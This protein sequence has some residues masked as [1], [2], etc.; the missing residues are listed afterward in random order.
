MKGTIG[1]TSTI[2]GI[3]CLFIAI[4]QLVQTGAPAAWDS[5]VRGDIANVRTV[6]SAEFLSGH[7]Y[8]T[9]LGAPTPSGFS[10]KLSAGSESQIIATSATYVMVS[11]SNSG[12]IFISTADATTTLATPTAPVTAA[13]LGTLPIDSALV[14]P[15]VNRYIAENAPSPATPG[16]GAKT[17]ELILK[18][19]KAQALGTLSTVSNFFFGS[20]GASGA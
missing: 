13:D 10:V 12:N 17:T 19:L 5:N 9:D 4:P 11:R 6:E 3:I 16:D 15:A 14:L 20:T 7:G 2:I 8:V 1:S 18:S